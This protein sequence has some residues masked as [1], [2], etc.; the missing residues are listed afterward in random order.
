MIEIF[1]NGERA[2][3][4]ESKCLATLLAAR[5]FSCSRIAVAINSEFVARSDYENVFLKAG[6]VVDVV[7]PVAGG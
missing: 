1:I 2:A 5:E 7:A 6:D 4:D 3:V